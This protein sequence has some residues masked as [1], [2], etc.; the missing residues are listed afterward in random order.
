MRNLNTNGNLVAFSQSDRILGT[1][2]LPGLWHTVPA[3]CFAD[4]DGDDLQELF[5][6]T[7]N[8]GDSVLVSQVELSDTNGIQKHRF[9]CTVSR[10][11]DALDHV[12]NSLG[13]FDMTGDSNPD[14][15]FQVTAGFSLQPRACYAWDLENDTIIRTP[16]AGINFR[17]PYFHVQSEDETLIYTT[18]TATQNYHSPVPYSDTAS[19]AVVFG[20]GMNFLFEPLAAGGAQSMTT[21]LPFPGQE[22]ELILAVTADRR[23]DLGRFTLRVLDQSGNILRIRKDVDLPKSSMALYWNQQSCIFTSDKEGYRLLAIDPDLQLKELSSGSAPLAII[24]SL[25]LDSDPASEL[26]L[27]HGANRTFAILDDQMK[28]L[29]SLEF[30]SPIPPVS[31]VSQISTGEGH[32]RF[33]IQCSGKDYT[34]VYGKNSFFHF[35]WTYYLALYVGC[36]LLFLGLQ[37]LFLFRNRQK[38]AKEEEI[39]ELQLKAVMNQLNPHFTFNAINSIGQ[40]MLKG[41]KK[42]GYNYFV[43]LSDLVRKSMKN[44]FEPYKTLAEE[45]EFVEQYLNIES[46]RFKGKLSWDLRVDSAV[47]RTVLIPKMLIHIFVENAIKHGIFHQE[48]G[49]SLDLSIRQNANGLDITINDDGIGREQAFRLEKKRGDGL[50]ILDNYLLLFN[51]QHRHK[52]SYRIVDRQKADP[53]QPGTQV[54]I[55]I[56][57]K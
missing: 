53:N 39:I 42:E 4:S 23:K 22:G 25:N 24:S 52:I 12:I 36:F 17:K 21:T 2:N 6:L 48:E 9:V 33:F 41:D 14:F 45:I 11:N 18:T 7:I 20:E 5:T 31:S 30:D 56:R 26:L 37:K 19:Y 32:H 50:R 43:S 40:L 57:F 8:A 1:W 49:G 29:A 15:V 54:I 35:R 13:Y 55:S 10:K 38:K 16:F 34:L 3:Y 47:D 44:A 51:K 27:F 46:F 28:S